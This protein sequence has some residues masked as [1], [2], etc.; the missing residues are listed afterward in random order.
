MS[1]NELYYLLRNMIAVYLPEIS[2]MKPVYEK[3]RPG[4]IRHS[5]ADITKAQTE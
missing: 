2:E 4:D 1:L 3:F 5:Y